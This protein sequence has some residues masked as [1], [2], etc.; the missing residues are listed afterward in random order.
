MKAF[1][2]GISAGFHDSSACLV[3]TYGVVHYASSEERFSRKKGD[4][5]FPEKAIDECLKYCKDNDGHIIKICLHENPSFGFPKPLKFPVKKY[6]EA[7]ISYLFS[8]R[9]L[10]KDLKILSNT[11]GI[12]INLPRAVAHGQGDIRALSEAS[13]YNGS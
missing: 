1:L 13:F 5:E 2:L 6:I 4:K 8:I 11:T 9:K 10:F 3:D 7:N 12:M